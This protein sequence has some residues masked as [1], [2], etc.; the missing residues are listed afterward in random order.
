MVFYLLLG[1]SFF[2]YWLSNALIVSGGIYLWIV[3]SVFRFTG[4]FIFASLTFVL[5]KSATEKLLFFFFLLP[6][7]EWLRGTIFSGFP[8]NMIGFSLNNPLEISQTI[9]ILGPYGQH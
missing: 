6:F 4:I 9:S 7:F 3:P 5:G 2:L 1:G 8:W